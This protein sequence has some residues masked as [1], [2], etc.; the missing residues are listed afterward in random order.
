MNANRNHAIVLAVALAVVACGDGDSSDTTATPATTA[1]AASAPPTTQ[2]P[3]TTEPADAEHEH[4][5]VGGDDEGGEEAVP[6]G[7]EEVDEA[8]PRLAVADADTG[9]V[10]LLDLAAGETIDTFEATGPANLSTDG[11]FVFATDYE[12]GAVTVIDAGSWVVDHG[13]HAHAYVKD[14]AVIGAL[15]G[16]NPA[17]VVP[18][19]GFTSVFFDGSG[20]ADVLH[21]DQLADGE[22]APELTLE[23]SSPHHGVVVTFADHFA[24]SIPGPTPDDLP[25]GIEVR[26]NDGDVEASFEECPEMHGEA[27]FAAGVLLACDDG[28]LLVSGTEGEWASE[29]LAYPK[30]AAKGDRTWSFA[31]AH[32]VPVVAGALGEDALLVVDR[33]TVEPRRIE[34]P[35][36]PVTV[37]VADGGEHLVALTADGE[38]HLI[39][40]ATG[41]IEASGQVTDPVDMEAEDGPAQPQVVVTGGRA[42][43][44]D[45][46]AGTVVEVD[47]RDAMRIARTIDVDVTPAQ[48]ALS[49]TE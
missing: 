46:V 14:P 41:G 24:V 25:V 3:A 2:V 38:L 43:V 23:T 19:E 22:V 13:D 5:D 27:A 11:R 4:D 15:E 21:E 37:A 29:K 28:V 32:G 1:S 31:H 35:V 17:H 6:P 49:G 47:Y 20:V 39:D 40:T 36:A 12:G 33:D 26:H 45:A 34:L 44:S 42:Y 10:E 7:A 9:A 30:G 16:P 18:N 8:E 48:L